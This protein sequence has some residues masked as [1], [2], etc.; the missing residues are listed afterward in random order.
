MEWAIFSKI[1]MAKEICETVVAVK[2]I[3]PSNNPLVALF[4]PPTDKETELA[5]VRLR[6]GAKTLLVSQAYLMRVPG[7]SMMARALNPPSPY[8]IVRR[9]LHQ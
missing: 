9:L 1:S 2:L 6:V 8:L 5:V 3:C 4:L 7:L